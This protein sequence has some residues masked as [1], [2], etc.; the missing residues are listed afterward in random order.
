MEDLDKTTD[1][2][3]T[4]ESQAPVCT[5]NCKECKPYQLQYCAAQTGYYA[6]Q[7][8]SALGTAITSLQEKVSQLSDTIAEMKGS[9]ELVD[10]PKIVNR[11]SSNRK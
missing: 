7:H 6:M 11:K 8:L 2:A 4:P 9:E 1:A 3:P 10:A 5:G